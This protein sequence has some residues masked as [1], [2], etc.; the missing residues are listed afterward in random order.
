MST[1]KLVQIMSMTGGLFSELRC[2]S[3]G[4]SFSEAE[5]EE[6][7]LNSGVDGG[8][9]DYKEVVYKHFFGGDSGTATGHWAP[10]VVPRD[11][12][13]EAASMREVAK[14]KADRGRGGL[15]GQDRWGSAWIE[16]RSGPGGFGAL[17][18][19]FGS[20]IAVG[21]ALCC[22]WRLNSQTQGG[23]DVSI[24]IRGALGVQRLPSSGHPSRHG[25]TAGPYGAA[26]GGLRVLRPCVRAPRRASWAH[27]LLCGHDLRRYG[28]PERP[29]G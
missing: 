6:L 8:T 21:L 15:R 27:A 24:G 10:E 11:R 2:E 14:M 28:Q 13:E 20:W 9:V 19:S 23:F 26:A 16:F 25:A 3:A 17:P 12:A 1:Q 18:H 7:L 22:I 4:N 29:P 5:L